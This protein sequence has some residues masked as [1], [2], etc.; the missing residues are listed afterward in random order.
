MR[1]SDAGKVPF[2]WPQGT[3]PIHHTHTIRLGPWAPA[4]AGV[5]DVGCARDRDVVVDR[6]WRA[7]TSLCRSRPFGVG[8][9]VR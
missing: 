5:A 2:E 4:F 3:F 7:V 8:V 9:G 6:F 1:R